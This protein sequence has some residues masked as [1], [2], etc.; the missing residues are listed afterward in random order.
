MNDYPMT[1]SD[2]SDS[3]INRPEEDKDD[4][5][6]TLRRELATAREEGRGEVVEAVTIAC[7]QVAEEWGS[8][9][10]TIQNVL[11]TILAALPE[12]EVKG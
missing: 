1:G 12:K 2:F 10:K 4:T 7:N 3:L 5:I 11:N 6:A 8:T 9:S